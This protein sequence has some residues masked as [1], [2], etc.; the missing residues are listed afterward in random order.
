M[1]E[2]IIIGIIS[3]FLSLPWHKKPNTGL[4]I[5]FAFI[6]IFLGLRYNFGRDY[7]AYFKGFIEINTNASITL[8][9]YILL[10]EPGWY[11]LNK[12]F[13]PV[14]FYGMTLF[15][16]LFNSFAYYKFIKRYVPTNYY[17]LAVFLYIFSTGL[18]LTQASAMRQTLA[19]NLF[20]MG[21]P[22]IENKSPIKYFLCLI[23]AASIHQSALILLPIYILSIANWKINNIV[24]IIIF[25]TYIILN[26]FG[27]LVLP[28]LNQFIF[29]YFNRYNEYTLVDNEIKFGTGLGFIY[30]SLIFFFVI[31]LE[32]RQNKVSS[33]LFKISI[34]YF[35]IVALSMVSPL[36]GRVGM[37]F[38]T[39]LIIAVVPLIL[40]SIN[41]K[42]LR[43]IFLLSFFIY[44]IYD[45]YNFF[46]DPYIYKYYGTYHTFFSS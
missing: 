36:I 12:L 11:L 29:I 32:K 41:R 25:S 33:L 2:L 46:N 27:K 21:I 15:F 45:F 5:S 23:V 9:D 16:A 42:K 28:N 34:L 8:Y 43:F 13:Q 20:L 3:V 7:E 31:L 24:G 37:Y 44:T 26:V 18:L 35:I 40:I 39:I 1:I 6:F 30:T 17:W 14:G 38:Q 19:I 10:A 4:K 22:F